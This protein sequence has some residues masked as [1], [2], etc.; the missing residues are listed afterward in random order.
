MIEEE[1]SKLLEKNWSHE[2]KLL[3][4]SIMDG[5]VYYKRLIPR[6]LKNDVICALQL[7][8][9]LKHQLEEMSEKLIE[10]E[11]DAN[12]KEAY[13]KD[14]DDNIDIILDNINNIEFRD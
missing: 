3:I 5:V 2:E 13:Y 4:T 10:Y 9:N 7:C 1:F 8:N 11:K 14:V 12:Y 6:S